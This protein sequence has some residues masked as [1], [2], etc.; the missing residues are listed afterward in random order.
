MYICIY[1]HRHVHIEYVYVCKKEREKG[2]EREREGER[3]RERPRGGEGG[4]EGR[5]A[6][7]LGWS[8]VDVQYLKTNVGN[9]FAMRG[10]KPGVTPK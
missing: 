6:L 5:R 9:N 4:R 10:R 7:V 8:N 3:E 2:R 1:V